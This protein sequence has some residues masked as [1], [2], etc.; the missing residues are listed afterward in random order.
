[1]SRSKVNT[2]EK[3]VLSSLNPDKVR[4]KKA[5][6]ESVIHLFLIY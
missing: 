2:S 3:E 5:K 1:M 4:E 6:R